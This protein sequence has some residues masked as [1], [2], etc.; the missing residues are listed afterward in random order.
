MAG[1]GADGGLD[2]SPRPTPL[3]RNYSRLSF[4]SHSRKTS[5]VDLAA[6]LHGAQLARTSSAGSAS[7]SA[8]ES[9]DPPEASSSKSPLTHYGLTTIA[10]RRGSSSSLKNVLDINSDY[11][12]HPRSSLSHEAKPSNPPTPSATAPSSPFKGQSNVA[13]MLQTKRRMASGPFA[14]PQRSHVALDIDTVTDEHI[15]SL[16]SYSWQNS[17]TGAEARPVP[18][19][20]RSRHNTRVLGGDQLPPLSPTLSMSSHSK[21][22]S[23][24]KSLSGSWKTTDC[25]Q[26][27]QSSSERQLSAAWQELEP[28]TVLMTP[29]TE[30]WRSYGGFIGSNRLKVRQAS[31]KSLKSISRSNSSLDNIKDPDAAIESDSDN[32]TS[33]EDSDIEVD[34]PE[35]LVD[36]QSDKML[37]KSPALS[38]KLTG[39][40][41]KSPSAT[42]S[43]ILKAH[44]KSPLNLNS[45]SS[46]LPPTVSTDTT[47]SGLVLVDL[48]PP[49]SE[50]PVPLDPLGPVDPKRYSSKTGARNINSFFI[51]GTAGEGGYGTVV[52]ARER[53]ADGWSTGVSRVAR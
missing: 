32:S 18:R 43:P 49:R 39:F 38:F 48:P 28:S 53:S 26:L 17:T 20:Q 46:Y 14:A 3:E 22:S 21:Q 34:E 37:S 47:A 15:S 11:F 27:K 36:T 23:P 10:T 25:N 29:T 19:R 9:A 4:V 52:R 35:E 30:E 31:Y 44:E 5:L 41:S 50:S 33:G 24:D 6:D 51:Q 42:S 16:A 7:S 12:S 2:Y 13:S 45:M 1:D 40:K 8:S